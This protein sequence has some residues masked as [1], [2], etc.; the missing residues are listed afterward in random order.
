MIGLKLR[1]VLILFVGD[2]LKNLKI[3]KKVLKRKRNL[4]SEKNRKRKQ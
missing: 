1:R 2:V 3:P 4:A